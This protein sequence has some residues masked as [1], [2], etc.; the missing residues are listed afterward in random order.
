MGNVL[1]ELG[2]LHDSEDPLHVREDMLMVPGGTVAELGHPE[3]LQERG[4]RGGRSFGGCQGLTMILVMNSWRAFL[5]LKRRL[6]CMTFCWCCW[7]I[8]RPISKKFEFN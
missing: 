8:S 6:A 2:D 5:V 3:E 7:S 1:G 4:V